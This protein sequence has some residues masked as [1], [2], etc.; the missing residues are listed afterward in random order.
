MHP[1]RMPKKGRGS[2]HHGQRCQP[3]HPPPVYPCDPRH[4]P[5]ILPV[6]G[7]RQRIALSH[8]ARMSV[9]RRE[10]DVRMLLRHRLERLHGLA[11]WHRSRSCVGYFW[12]SG[13]ARQT[14]VGGVACVHRVF[15]RPR[16]T[17]RHDLA[18]PSVIK[19][20]K[21]GESGRSAR[22]GYSSPLLLRNMSQRNFYGKGANTGDSSSAVPVYFFSIKR[23][24]FCLSIAER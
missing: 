18:S 23:P 14:V 12:L 19:R 10:A 13:W 16:Y 11:I 15:H 20:L 24:I 7:R 4:D 2:D 6:A 3:S 5:R 8:E 22:S 9:N 1:I 17:H 21:M